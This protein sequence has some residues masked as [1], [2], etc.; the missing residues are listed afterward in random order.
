LRNSGQSNS[1]QRRG[2]KNRKPTG[3][4]GQQGGNGQRTSNSQSGGQG[5]SGG[6][7]N[8]S[9]NSPSSGQQRTGSGQRNASSNSSSSGQQRTGSSQRNSSS[10]GK[11]RNE[12]SQA[13]ASDTSTLSSHMPTAK[14]NDWGNKKS[15]S[16]NENNPNPR[17]KNKPSGGKNRSGQPN[18]NQTR[19]KPHSRPGND[20]A[21]QKTAATQKS[22]AP[23]ENGKQANGIDPFELFCAYHLGITKD[24]GYRTANINEVANRFRSEPG[25]I[26]QTLKEYDMDAE[27][28]LDR[29]FDMGLAQLDIQVA[30]EGVDRLELARGI[31]QD[32]QDAPRV[33]RDWGKILE[34]DR[35]ENQKIFRN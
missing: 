29:D 35:K 19:N 16:K 33:K 22:S 2:Q 7:R 4:N 28:L 1:S 25:M 8:A 3:K 34:E 10:R 17:G 5:A 26:K 20:S 11:S 23:R 21:T 12:I 24:K 13:W 30:P 27:S 32:F 18:R 6:Q 9:P 15:A 14:R 31:Y